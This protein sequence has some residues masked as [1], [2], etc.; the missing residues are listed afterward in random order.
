[1]LVH[2]TYLQQLWIVVHHIPF[3]FMGLGLYRLIKFRS[4]FL[5]NYYVVC[6]NEEIW[7][8]GKFEFLC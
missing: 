5:M 3:K 1:M 7:S 8:N 4:V 6:S 2:F